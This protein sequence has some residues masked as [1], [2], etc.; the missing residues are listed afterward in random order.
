M[1]R[2]KD[3]DARRLFRAVADSSLQHRYLAAMFTGA[4]EER[5]GA[6][7]PAIEAYRRAANAVP[8]AQSA[9]VALG[10][11]LQQRGRGEESRALLE[12]LLIQ[13]SPPTDPQWTYFF[14]ET[15]TVFARVQDLFN[16]IER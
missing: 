3:G 5:R 16:E 13:E 10:H 1:L 2:G 7:E 8:A 9:T 14:E 4:L 12:S 15:K 6:I 11:L